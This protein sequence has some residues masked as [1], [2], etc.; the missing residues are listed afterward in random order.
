M[1]KV[2]PR[3]KRLL[4]A[5]GMPPLYRTLP[6]KAYSH[7]TDEVLAWISQRPGSVSYVLDKLSVGGYIAY[8]PEVGQVVGSGLCAG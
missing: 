8:D 4:A 1:G 6:G 5:K 7:K 3:D 2:K